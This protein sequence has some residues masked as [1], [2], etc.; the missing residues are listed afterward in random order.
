M[1]KKKA[2]K[3][4]GYKK[5]KGKGERIGEGWPSSYT[6]NTNEKMKGESLF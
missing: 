2:M 3:K 5:G 6:M 1:G 4:K